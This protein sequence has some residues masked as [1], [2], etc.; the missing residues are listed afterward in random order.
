MELSKIN[1]IVGKKRKEGGHGS[2]IPTVENLR[3]QHVWREKSQKLGSG[4][5]EMTWKI[6]GRWMS[7]V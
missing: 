5:W 3:N 1:A 4:R 2:G 6:L 7:E